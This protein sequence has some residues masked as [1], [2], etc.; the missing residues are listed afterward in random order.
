M[1]RVTAVMDRVERS[2]V[3]RR[4]RSLI[5]LVT[6]ASLAAACVVASSPAAQSTSSSSS[7]SAPAQPTIGPAAPASSP[8][9]A[10]VVPWADDPAPAY[11]APTPPPLPADARPCKAADLSV[12]SGDLGYGLGNSN[13]PLTFT[14]KSDSACVLTG[15]AT[16][17]GVTSDRTLVPLR[18]HPGSYFGDPGPIANIAPGGIA[19]LNVSGGDS[20]D[21]T[22]AGKTRIYPTLRIGLPSGDTVDVPSHGFD[23]ACGVWASLFGVP[24]DVVPPVDVPLS[25]ISATIEAPATAT[26]GQDLVYTVTLSN[27][28]TASVSLEP[29]PVYDEFVG[30]GE[31]TWVATILHYHL[32]C[33]TTTAIPAGGSVIFE[34]HLALPADQPV[35]MAKFGWDV[36]GGACPCAAAQLEVKARG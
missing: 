19:A 13:L 9:V 16:V 27:P 18:V 15:T 17:G 8:T 6:I 30:S 35:G 31:Q 21:A 22:L 11:V 25:P 1:L 34:M 7:A 36:Q 29:C 28:T 2:V 10:G 3:P 33:D 24:A 4:A 20:C 32:N 26:P 5:A 23:T 14:N 12:S